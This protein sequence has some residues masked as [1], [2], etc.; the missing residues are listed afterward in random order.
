MILRRR[1][2]HMTKSNGPNEDIILEI[3]Y[4]RMGFFSK[5][6]YFQNL[7]SFGIKNIILDYHYSRLLNC[8]RYFFLR[9]LNSVK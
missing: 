2:Q 6:V 4:F 7:V 1:R 5:G 9:Y 3:G 8:Y